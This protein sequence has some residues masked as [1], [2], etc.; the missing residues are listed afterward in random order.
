MN[1]SKIA[2]ISTVSGYTLNTEELTGLEN[3]MLQRELEEKMGKMKFWGKIF[4]T[5]QDYLI[6]FS[7]DWNGKFPAKKFYFW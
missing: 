7:T 3:A 6:V 2:Q 4:G 5:V 1:L